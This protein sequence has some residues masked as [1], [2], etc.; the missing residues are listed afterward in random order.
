MNMI[1]NWKVVLLNAIFLHEDGAHRDGG[2]DCFDCGVER[3][4]GRSASEL[5][6]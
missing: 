3:N 5:E 6:E 4:P 2:E 1:I